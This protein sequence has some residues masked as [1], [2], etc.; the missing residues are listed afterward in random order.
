[1]NLS[2]ENFR[3]IRDPEHYEKIDQIGRGKFQTR[4]LPFPGTG[5]LSAC[6]EIDEFLPTRG[7][8]G[9]KTDGEI[10]GKKTEDEVANWLLN[11]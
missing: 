4:Y 1:M 6:S 7:G 9:V 5:L 8:R 2:P 3:P 10:F 11:V